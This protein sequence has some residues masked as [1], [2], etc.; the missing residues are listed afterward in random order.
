MDAVCWVAGKNYLTGE[1]VKVNQPEFC[2]GRTDSNPE[3]G[4]GINI[5]YAAKCQRDS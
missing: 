4:I 5:V 3:S 1:W 2:E